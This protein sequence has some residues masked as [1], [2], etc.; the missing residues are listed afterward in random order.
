MPSKGRCWMTSKERMAKLIADNRIW[1]GKSGSNMPRYKT[2]LS[3]VQ[4][5]IVPLTI[6]LH[7]EVGHNQAAKQ[8]LKKKRS[9]L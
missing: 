1:F 3:E 7:N 2:F 9:E 4:Q 6:W 8:E 5:G